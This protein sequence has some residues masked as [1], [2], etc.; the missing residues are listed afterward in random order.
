MINLT[1][2]SEDYNDALNN[3]VSVPEPGEQVRS[4][5]VLGAVLGAVRPG[6]QA[7]LNRVHAV[8][9]GRIA[10]R[11]LRV[12]RFD[13]GTTVNPADGLLDADTMTTIAL[14]LKSYAAPGVSLKNTLDAINVPKAGGVIQ[15]DG[16]GGFTILTQQGATWGVKVAPAPSL[17]A[18][19]VEVELVDAMA[20]VNYCI[21]IN[22]VRGAAAESG[23]YPSVASVSKFR[24]NTPGQDPRA[25]VITYHFTVWG[26][27]A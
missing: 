18:T 14:L 6:Y 11:A 25:T 27:Q 1:P 3:T 21:Q 2:T 26:Q 15:T 16:V 8:V 4:G 19:Y 13:A 12:G 17:G 5:G 23:C 9:R 10:F 7:L 22:A 24:L 20:S